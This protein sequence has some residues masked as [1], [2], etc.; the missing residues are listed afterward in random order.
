[1]EGRLTQRSKTA[2]T[3]NEMARSLEAEIGVI[4]RKLEER[5]SAL[6]NKSAQASR[7]AEEEIR[8]AREAQALAE[9]EDRDAQA[10]L[11]AADKLCRQAEAAAA[12]AQAQLTDASKTAEETGRERS[13]ALDAV[14]REL[15]RL[16][17]L[18]L[19]QDSEFQSE[20]AQLHS[21]FTQSQAD[22]EYQRSV[23]QR[24]EARIAGSR[25]DFE[26]RRQLAQQ[27][28]ENMTVERRSEI[29][30][31]RLDVEQLRSEAS[32]M[33]IALAAAE[34]DAERARVEVRAAKAAL[35]KTTVMAGAGALPN[36][37]CLGA[38]MQQ[39]DT[40]AGWRRH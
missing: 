35:V 9:A 8:C 10:R 4:E 3:K 33:A 23:V 12:D 27:A 5:E 14:K 22:V 6:R 39:D 28:F 17:D 15:Q 21:V 31:C 1:M 18:L 34:K 19:A 25:E 11:A 20:R 40:F 13:V 36:K 7:V 30:R 16:S 2:F 24:T 29:E 26:T 38:L 32:A 37:T